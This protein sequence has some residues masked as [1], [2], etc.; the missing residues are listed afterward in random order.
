MQ[1]SFLI[2][3]GNKDTRQIQLEDLFSKA[4]FN[5]TNNPDYLFIQKEEGKRSI[6]LAEVKKAIKWTQEKPYSGNAKILAINDAKT[7]TTEAQNALLK[8]LEE[9]AEYMGIYLLTQSKNDVLETILSRCKRIELNTSTEASSSS[10][11]ELLSKGKGEQFSWALE[12]GKEDRDVVL[13]KLE[14]WKKEARVI[15]R[16]NPVEGYAKLIELIADT[17]QNLAETNVNQKLALENL[18]MQM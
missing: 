4:N 16:Q 6:G 18:I 13:E 10:L 14:D 8:T 9:P 5:P 15:L 12:M 7:L 17:A 2:F 11:R 1:G 3:G